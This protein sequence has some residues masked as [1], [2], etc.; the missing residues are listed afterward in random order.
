MKKQS[1]RKKIRKRFSL[2]VFFFSYCDCSLASHSK[3]LEFTTKMI[4]S[5]VFYF[6]FDTIGIHVLLLLLLSIIFIYIETFVTNSFSFSWCAHKNL[7]LNLCTFILWDS[8]VC[9]FAI[10]Y[11]ILTFVCA[12]FPAS[13]ADCCWCWCS[14]RLLLPTISDGFS[15]SISFCFISS[16][17]CY[18]LI[19]FLLEIYIWHL[20]MVAFFF[21][22]ISALRIT[23]VSIRLVKWCN[24]INV[25]TN[26]N[27]GIE[28]N[29][30]SIPDMSK[31]VVRNQLAINRCIR[32]LTRLQIMS[33]LYTYTNN[34]FNGFNWISN[35]MSNDQHS[36]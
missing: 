19:F 33:I 17:I 2:W 4:G 13:M 20:E 28:S 21:Q 6:H 5:L 22:P 9:L 14:Y 3:S 1:Q 15:L 29:W 10:D 35:V 26:Q 11:S 12:L 25:Q 23:F 8:P 36:Q 34:L 31:V 18:I 32:I 16:C 7:W 27:I 24:L 30:K